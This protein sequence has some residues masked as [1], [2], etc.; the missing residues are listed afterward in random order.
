MKT[1]L[2]LLIFLVPANGL[3]VK[4]LSNLVQDLIENE[5]VPSV[6]SV[7]SCWS[8]FDQQ[9]FVKSSKIPVQLS[10]RFKIQPRISDDR[11]NKLW[12]FIDVRCVG[13]DKFL[14]GTDN[15]YFAHPYR[16]IM[17]EPVEERMVNLTFLPDSNVIFVHFNADQSRFDLKQGKMFLFFRLGVS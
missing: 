16:W 15:A 8:K 2:I 4:I 3:E 5:K 7:F 11:T 6:L 12:Y 17:F 10:N 1:T 13:S 9:A 14:H